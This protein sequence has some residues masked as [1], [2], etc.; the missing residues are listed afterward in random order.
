MSNGQPTHVLYFWRLLLSILRRLM[1]SNTNIFINLLEEVFENF[2]LPQGCRIWS[3][4]RFLFNKTKKVYFYVFI[5]NEKL[6]LIAGYLNLNKINPKF[7]PKP[8]PPTNFYPE[9][10]VKLF[11]LRFVVISNSPVEWNAASKKSSIVIS[12]ISLFNES[13]LKINKSPKRQYLS[14]TFYYEKGHDENGTLLDHCCRFQNV[15]WLIFG[16]VESHLSK[17]LFWKN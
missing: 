7:L 10:R 13:L 15:I 4:F 5:I 16:Q 14:T 2:F 3:I 6:R 9:N 8:V 11:L 1:M 17:T 12:E